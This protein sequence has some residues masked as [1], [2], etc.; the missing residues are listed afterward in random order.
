MASSGLS[1]AQIDELLPVSERESEESTA[2]ITLPEFTQALELAR[3]KVATLEAKS[4][5]QEKKIQEQEA[6]IKAIEEHLSKPFIKRLF[7]K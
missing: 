7:K 1:F 2:L 4:D 3:S 6:R 5:E